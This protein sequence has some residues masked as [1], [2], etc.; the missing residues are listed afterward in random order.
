VKN[1]PSQQLIPGLHN[2]LKRAFLTARA[3]I[4]QCVFHYAFETIGY[5]NRALIGALRTVFSQ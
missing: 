4:A 3:S 1:A 5:S 2:L